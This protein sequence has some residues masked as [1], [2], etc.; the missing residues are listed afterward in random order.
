MGGP[1]AHR[2]FNR[3][4]MHKKFGKWLSAMGDAYVVQLDSRRDESSTGVLISP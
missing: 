1:L 2:H 3:Y 4:K